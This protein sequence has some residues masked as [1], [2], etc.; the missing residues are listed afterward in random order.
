M[1]AS[2]DLARLAAVVADMI[3]ESGNPT[4]AGIIHRLAATVVDLE[5]QIRM[6]T[7]ATPTTGCLVCGSPLEQRA[8][9]RRKKFCSEAHRRQAQTEARRA[10]N[11]ANVKLVP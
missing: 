2:A 4:F 7:P 9:G 8:T 5:A 10:R 1:S 3:D 11:G 6:L